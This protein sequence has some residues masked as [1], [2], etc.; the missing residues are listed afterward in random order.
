MVEQDTLRRLFLDSV[1]ARGLEL[2]DVAAFADGRWQPREVAG[3][4]SALVILRDYD[5]KEFAQ[6]ATAFVTGLDAGAREAWY[7]EFTR[8]SFLVGDPDRV[9]DRLAGLLSQRTKSMAWVWSPA[10]RETL[11]LRRLLKPLRTSG[12]WLGQE[13]AEYDLGGGGSSSRRALT[14]AA[15]GLSLEE[16][17]V[18]LNHTLCECLITGVLSPGDRVAIRHVARIESLP[19]GCPYARVVPDPHD[20]ARLTAVTCVS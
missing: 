8:T 11:G 18:H 20:T 3:D 10:D 5:P 17:L 14:L 13:D 19:P 15:D 1:A 16:Y 2:E 6:G 4:T 9:P 7:R 12:P